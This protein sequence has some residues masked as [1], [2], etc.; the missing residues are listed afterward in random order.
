MER[1]KR[2]IKIVALFAAVLSWVT[3]AFAF[4]S[5]PEPGKTGAPGEGNCVDCH[6]SFPQNS[7]SGSV[8]LTGLPQ[9]GY[10]PGTRYNLTVTVAQSDRIRWGFQTTAL[11]EDGSAAGTFTVT[12]TAMTQMLNTTIGGKQRFYVEH[13]ST[14]T[15]R[16]KQ[17]S[18]TFNFDWTAPASDVGPIT[19]YVAG[20]A[21]NGD[22]TSR[23]DNNYTNKVRITAAAAP[24]PEAPS[25][26]SLTPV[27]GPIAGGTTV[28]FIGTNFRQ[29]IVATFDGVNVP[30]TFVNNKSITAV[31]PPHAPGTVDVAVRNTDGQ[32]A[33]LRGSFTYEAAPGASVLLIAPNGNEVL[34]SGG[35]PFQ[36][37]W[38]QAVGAL[39]T[40]KLE[41]STD[42]GQTFSSEIVT[43][44][45]DSQ[46]SFTYAVPTSI[47]TDKARIRLSV[48][49]NGVVVSDTSDQDFR[50]LPAPTI[51]KIT[52]TVTSKIQ[53]KITGTLFKNG[54]VIEVNDNPVTTKFKSATS[55]VGKKISKSLAGTLI[56]VRVR[57]PDGTVSVETTITP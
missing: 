19:F 21:A 13:T 57:N 56:R 37:R 28:T 30:T 11:T 3:V 31:T 18:A 22:G 41:L 51:T 38:T 46:N 53:L 2:N 27:N 15:Q 44:L 48:E 20:N 45:P 42:S 54:S 39:A 43:N 6:N 8:S 4:S 23:G 10:V 5:G 1:T 26:T 34:S 35:L 36:I 7:G 16:G 55:L 29:G 47:T 25:L 33:T 49:L 9:N 17:S 52:P 50:I 12:S 14:G 32:T 40:Q 24:M